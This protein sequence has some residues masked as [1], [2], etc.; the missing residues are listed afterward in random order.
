MVGDGTVERLQRF[1]RSRLATQHVP[2]I[3]TVGTIPRLPNGKVDRD[4]LSLAPRTKNDGSSPAAAFGSPIEASLARIWCE[5]LRREHVAAEDN[6]FDLGGDSLLVATLVY[7]IGET[8]GVQLGMP[9]I[10]RNPVFRQMA[11][12]LATRSSC[13]RPAVITIHE[14]DA[15]ERS[16]YF[17]Y[18][19]SHEFNLARMLGVKRNI[20]G[21]EVGW[22]YAWRLAL[23]RGDRSGYP[24]M[25]RMV[26]PFCSTIFAHAGSRPFVVAG[27]SFAGRMAFE[28]ARQLRE[29]GAHIDAVLLFDTVA[30]PPS[31]LR[32]AWNKMLDVGRGRT[33]LDWARL[34]RIVQRFRATR[35]RRA[36]PRSPQ[37]GAEGP[38]ISD[39][40]TY[41]PSL[42]WELM[43][44][45]Y[46][47][48]K[49]QYRPSKL[50]C[51]GIV[52]VASDDEETWTRR[53]AGR[54]LGWQ[55]FFGIDLQIIGAE[56]DHSRL[57]REYNRELE[58]NLTAALDRLT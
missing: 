43:E 8:I 37:A 41:E 14:G 23:E 45:L 6:F 53:S 56:S 57:P 42:A 13:V 24:S 1:L 32:I 27:Y 7:C 54:D 21:V 15:A 46:E 52:V 5:L 30:L 28:S 18:S 22:P 49:K 3:I 2:T 33:R 19:G 16:I 35:L 44:K 40:D 36:G 48:I 29:R 55:K 34:T 50:D 9:E 38:P 17:I 25:E 26:E 10:F 47:N 39:T 51:R 12:L 20:Y 31:P 11:Q 4:Q 58:L